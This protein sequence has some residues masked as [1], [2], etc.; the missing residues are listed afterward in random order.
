MSSKKL[1]KIAI[2]FVALR[3]I[4]LTVS[5]NT[6][7]IIFL[8]LLVS[9]RFYQSF[10]KQRR[11]SSGK[12]FIIISY[13][14]FLFYLLFPVSLKAG[15]IINEIMYDLPGSDEGREWI[16][17]Y[18]S[19]LEVV[20]LESFNIET[21][22][23]HRPLT[24]VSGSFLLPPKG[25]AIIIR[26]YDK[27]ENDWPSLSGTIFRSSFSLN[28]TSGKIVLKNSGETGA[29]QEII[30]NSEWGATGNGESLQKFGDDFQSSLPTPGYINKVLPLKKSSNVKASSKLNE[31]SA[32][33][34]SSLPAESESF[35]NSN[36]ILLP[37]ENQSE[38]SGG[39]TGTT[40]TDQGQIN[41][42]NG[43]GIGK[44]LVAITGLLALS[45]LAIIL[46][47]LKKEKKELNLAQDIKIIVD[48]DDT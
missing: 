4:I 36:D 1:E 31:K 48:E 13:A 7:R 21:A 16:E 26:D 25:Y 11:S 9:H 27:F 19:G 41:D 14:F 47:T 22:A 32:D 44:W 2:Y 3:K 24:L 46:S 5:A 12:F 43:R 20:N 6:F 15:V 23:N 42:L 18:N 35:E 10:P 17:I 33:V 39:A 45:S 34:S 37:L 29:V 28:N 8:A 40:I 30:Y 38:F